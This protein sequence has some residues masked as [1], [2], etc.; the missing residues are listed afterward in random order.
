[1]STLRFIS[2]VLQLTGI[3]LVLYVVAIFVRA[4]VF[5]L[6]ASHAIEHA[7]QVRGHLPNKTDVPDNLEKNFPPAPGTVL[8]RI[9][10]PRLNA[11][12]VIL[13]DDGSDEL[14]L[15]A[16][17][18]PGTAEPGQHGN[19]VIAA[20]RDTFFRSLRNIAEGDEVVLT[21]LNGSIRYRV[22]ALRVTKP[23]DV[24][25]LKSTADSRLTLITC[26]PFSYIGAAPYRFIV[27]AKR[28]RDDRS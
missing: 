27:T 4:K 18:V 6:Q 25:V 26:Y 12:S 13:E 24:S 22:E 3:V 14:N 7:A 19:V 17:H 5:N 15:G 16:G 10:I 2:R 8:G 11:S 1:M 23:D 20:H 9:E 21:T 28:I